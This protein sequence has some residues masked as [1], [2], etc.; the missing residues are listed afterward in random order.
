MVEI[1][2]RYVIVI[3]FLVMFALSMSSYCYYQMFMTAPEVPPIE[4]T[5][6]GFIGV[7]EPFTDIEM[8]MVEA[9]KADEEKDDALT[10]TPEPTAAPFFGGSKNGPIIALSCSAY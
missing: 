1:D 2:G 5:A 7:N 4:V 9:V 6:S 8:V 10:L 3:A